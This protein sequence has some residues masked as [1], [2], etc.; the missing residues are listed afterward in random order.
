MVNGQ[1]TQID[2][3]SGQSGSKRQSMFRSQCGMN[4]D[5]SAVIH[6]ELEQIAGIWVGLDMNILE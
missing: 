5:Y 2:A 4:P 1:T 6:S 3:V